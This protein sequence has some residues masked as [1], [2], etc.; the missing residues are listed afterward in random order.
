MLEPPDFGRLISK[1]RFERGLRY[2][3]RGPEGVEHSLGVEPW[4]EV[5]W[6]LDGFDKTRREK[7]RPGSRLTPGECMIAWTGQSGPGGFHIYLLLKG[8]LNPW[9]LN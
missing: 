3:A 7:F 2:W 9:V 5:N 6:F 1:D 8:N 4:G